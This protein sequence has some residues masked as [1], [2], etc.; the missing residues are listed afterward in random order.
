[1]SPPPPAHPAPSSQ[2]VLATYLI[3]SMH[4]PEQA[5]AV[6]AGEQSTGTFVRVPGETPRLVEQHGAR[7]EALTELPPAERPSLPGIRPPRTA[8][9]PPGPGRGVDTP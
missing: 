5:A 8:D 3:E 2:R 7:I 9:A 1:M 4:P 6:L